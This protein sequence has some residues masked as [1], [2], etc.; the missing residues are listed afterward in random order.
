[1]R[2]SSGDSRPLVV[3]ATRINA[4]QR[5]LLREAVKKDG[6]QAKTEEIGRETR[7]NEEESHRPG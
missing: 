6:R 5:L 1:M 4:L 3:I 7:K 2:S